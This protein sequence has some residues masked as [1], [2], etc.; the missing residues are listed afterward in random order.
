[1][2]S[3]T[4]QMIDLIVNCTDVPGRGQLKITSMNFTYPGQRSKIP[5]CL[6]FYLAQTD[7]MSNP[8]VFISYREYFTCALYLPPNTGRPGQVVPLRV[9]H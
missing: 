8:T 4:F 1:M 9:P 7:Y 6:L 2:D 5:L 3:M